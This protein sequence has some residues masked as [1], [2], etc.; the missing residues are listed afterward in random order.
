MQS[1]FILMEAASIALALILVAGVLGLSF[2][3]RSQLSHSIV[4]LQERMTVHAEIQNVYDRGLVDFWRAYRGVDEELVL[5]SRED[6]KQL[7]NLLAICRQTSESEDE[8]SHDSVVQHLVNE[9][10]T[11]ANRLLART[12]SGQEKISDEHQLRII[13]TRIG[14]S[15]SATDRMEFRSL[16][17]ANRRLGIYNRL[18]YILL[19]DFGLFS[20]GTIVWVRRTQERSIWQLLDQL[21]GMVMEVKKGNLIVTGEIP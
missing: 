18:L 19:I 10:D 21:Y 3:I 8:S 13:E 6:M 11:I 20:I 5:R 17:D 4:R 12:G 15:F 9:H 7:Q 14:G 2:L 16:S 1:R